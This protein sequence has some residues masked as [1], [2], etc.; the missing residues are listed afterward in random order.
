M[1][2]IHSWSSI[3]VSRSSCSKTCGGLYRYFKI[4]CAICTSKSYSARENISV[5]V[6]VVSSYRLQ[7][8][9]CETDAKSHD[10]NKAGYPNGQSMVSPLLSLLMCLARKAGQACV[11]Y[12]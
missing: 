2:P 12:S 3:N 6:A 4:L 11:R 1:L 9:H 5:L 7:V 8:L 10:R